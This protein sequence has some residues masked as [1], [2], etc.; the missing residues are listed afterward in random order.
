VKNRI[1]VKAEHTYGKIFNGG[2]KTLHEPS[3]RE[4]LKKAK[5]YIHES[6]E[7]E[8]ILSV[9]KAID[10]I[11]KGVSGIVNAMPFGCMPGT[12]VTSLMRAISKDYNVPS[13]SIPY[14]GTE[15]VT[16]DL[17]L[18]AFMHQACEFKN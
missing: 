7:G 9:G 8:T 4:I 5:P 18:E 13:I 1:Q 11:D 3:T 10:L 16:T 2:L 14:D 6:F 12:I 17:Q 15:S